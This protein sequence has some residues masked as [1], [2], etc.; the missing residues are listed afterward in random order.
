MM[1]M[2]TSSR[3]QVILVV[4]LLWTIAGP[5]A[6]AFSGCVAMGGMC[7]S[8]CALTS[9]VLSRPPNPISP[10]LITPVLIQGAN[11]H[12]MAFIRVP[13]PPPRSIFTAI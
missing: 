13:D 8:P 10:P 1:I 2:P 11:Y 12:P 6:M 5:I 9:C 3:R 4:L 7:G